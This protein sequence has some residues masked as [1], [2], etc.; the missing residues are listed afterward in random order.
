M[1][2]QRSRLLQAALA[3]V[4]MFILMETTDNEAYYS[5]GGK[6][7]LA[8]FLLDKAR[9]ELFRE[10]TA[11]ERSTFDSLVA[12]LRSMELLKDGRSVNI[13][14]QLLI[15]LDIVVNNNSMRQ[16]AM[17]FRRGLF[18]VQRYLNTT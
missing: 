9:P 1:P 8:H 4:G 17:K 6:A 7:T 16:T 2:Q 12:T 14:E 18:T 5:D 15:F 11:L 3:L 10:V 13:E